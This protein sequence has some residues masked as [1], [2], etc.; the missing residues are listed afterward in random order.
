MEILLLN[1][2]RTNWLLYKIWKNRG[3]EIICVY[4]VKCNIIHKARQL[5]MQYY[6]CPLNFSVYS[7]YETNP[8]NILLWSSEPVRYLY[9][10][11]NLQ[12]FN[13]FIAH[14]I[15]GSRLWNDMVWYAQQKQTT[16]RNH[17]STHPKRSVIKFCYILGGKSLQ[18]IDLQSYQT[19]VYVF[20]CIAKNILT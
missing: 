4:W 13:C 10:F 12:H 20:K 8:L 14:T 7:E 17:V 9:S 16:R 19:S 11:N 3:R 1:K 15:G 6:L 18:T 5:Y 2:K